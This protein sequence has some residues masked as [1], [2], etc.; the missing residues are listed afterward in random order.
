MIERSVFGTFA[1]VGAAPAPPIS[2]DDGTEWAD[3]PAREKPPIINAGGS[4]NLGS[5]NFGSSSS[6][7]TSDSVMP[8]LL[9]QPIDPAMSRERR[10]PF[11]V[12]FVIGLLLGIIIGAITALYSVREFVVR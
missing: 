12:G 11:P 1:A 9:D 6:I 10:K 7:L 2:V 8:P 5:A 4:Q 3:V